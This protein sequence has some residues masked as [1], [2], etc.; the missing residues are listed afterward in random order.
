MIY[1]YPKFSKYELI[2][3]R[4]GGA[5]L[6]NLLFTWS[7]AMVVAN[8]YKLEMIWPTW[9]SIKIGPWIRQEAD[10]R[11]YADIFR[12]KLNMCGGF[13][14]YFRLLF[15]KKIYVSDLNKINWDNIKDN[16]III[17]EDY[18][19][20]GG[21]FQMDFSGLEN[22]RTMIS[23]TIMSSLRKKGENALKFDAKNA[24]NVHVRLG[25]FSK[26]KEL[27][28]SGANNVR[29]DIQWYIATI[30]KIRAAVGWTVPVNVFSDGKEEEIRP[31]LELE[32]VRRVTFGNS[33]ADIIALSK[34]DLLIA[35]G[36]SFSLW[37][38]F[39]GNCS[40]ISYPNQIKDYVYNGK[41]GFEIELGIEA[42]LDK[43]YIEKLQRMYKR[44]E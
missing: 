42:E 32:K 36:S 37:A 15:S 29:I 4:F 26:S 25:D 3:V 6:G 22:Y 24:I 33:I 10:K 19:H 20:P 16:D 43:K 38:R 44:I 35:S 14:K 17:Y 18:D 40:S 23:N 39:L 11:L 12:N 5:G 2:G 41:S 8:Q 1:I 7:R 21:G 30:K 9:V 28:D 13:E 34:A 31:L 27:L